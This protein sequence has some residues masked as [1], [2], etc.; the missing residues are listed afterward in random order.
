LTV[1]SARWYSSGEQVSC[2]DLDRSTSNDEQ[3]ASS[4]AAQA[5]TRRV[6]MLQDDRPID[7]LEAVPARV[8]E[9]ARADRYVGDR[10]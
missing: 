5:S 4:N 1:V 3:A 10:G 7:L 6:G 9:T 2:L 8:I